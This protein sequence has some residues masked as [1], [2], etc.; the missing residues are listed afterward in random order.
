MPDIFQT[1]YIFEEFFDSGKNF[2]NKVGY[3]LNI[4]LM[5]KIN[6]SVPGGRVFAN[7]H[8]PGQ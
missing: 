8:P 2:K 4:V 3:H 6:Y 1:T 7:V 5:K